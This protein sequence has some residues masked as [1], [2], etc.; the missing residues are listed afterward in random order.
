MAEIS[1]DVQLYTAILEQNVKKIKKL[2]LKK[3][4][5]INFIPPQDHK[6][7]VLDVANTVIDDILDEQIDF[8]TDIPYED[9]MKCIGI[10]TESHDDVDIS[11]FSI[12]LQKLCTKILELKNELNKAHDIQMALKLK[13]AKTYEDVQDVAGGPHKHKRKTRK[14]KTKHLRRHNKRKT[15]KSKTKHL[16]RHNKRKTRK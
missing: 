6:K 12:K 9:Y 15:R 11:K 1:N 14:S 5:N 4:I 8:L 2:L 3:D 7:T 16:R 13:G 10:D